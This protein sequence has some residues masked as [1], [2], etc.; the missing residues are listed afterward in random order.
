LTE[1]GRE[2]QRRVAQARS[3]S[4]RRLVADWEPESPE[5][6]AMIERLSGELATA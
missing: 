5:V 6:D 4:L 3:A 1:P 2:A